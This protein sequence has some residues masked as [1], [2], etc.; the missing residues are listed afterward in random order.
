[1][2]T[3]IELLASLRSEIGKGASRRLRHADKVPA[4]LYGA[5][6][7]AVAL[8]LDHN[9]V[10][11]AQEEEQFYSQI[12]NLVVDGK[13]VDV[14]VKDMQRHPFKR[15]VTH[16]DFQRIVAGEEIHTTVPVHFINE[17]TAPAVKSEG[18]VVSHLINEIEISC[19]PKD[20][21]EFIEVDVSGVALGSTLHLSDVKLPAGVSSVEL[22]KGE[23]HDV[24]VVSIDLPKAAKD[25]DEDGGEEEASEE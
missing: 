19:L 16:I 20:L 13:P 3:K 15:K 5:G 2:S 23:E 4:V 17:D 18:G 21:P 22:A 12:I 8:S 24:A 6:Q 14:I 25:E 10:I 1:M 11:K 9:K 7:D